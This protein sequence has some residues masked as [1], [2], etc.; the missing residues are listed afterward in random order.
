VGG[1]SE[2]RGRV[3]GG[4]PSRSIIFN[5]VITTIVVILHAY[6]NAKKDGEGKAQRREYFLL[7][8]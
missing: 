1:A 7:D 8:H 3:A 5:I 6:E 2:G 4:L